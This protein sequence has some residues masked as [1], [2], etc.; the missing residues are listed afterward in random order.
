MA[1]LL[2]LPRIKPPSGAAVMLSGPAPWSEVTVMAKA[3]AAPRA[4]ATAATEIAFMENLPLC[5]LLLRRDVEQGARIVVFQRPQR[6]VGAFLDIADAVTDTPAIGELGA[7]MPVHHHATDA[8]GRHAADQR[9]A[10][11]L[12]ESLVALVE[13]QIA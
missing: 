8:H 11:P 7:A 10:V 9:V 13:H 1:G 12:R 4:K 3:G 2:P 6:T 5:P